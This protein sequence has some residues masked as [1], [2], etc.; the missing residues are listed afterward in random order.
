MGQVLAAWVENVLLF[1]S[2]HL[3]YNIVCYEHLPILNSMC[4]LMV[5]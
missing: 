2:L 3:K 1:K 5:E 4:E